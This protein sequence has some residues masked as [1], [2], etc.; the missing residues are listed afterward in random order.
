MTLGSADSA[1]IRSDDWKEKETNGS[2]CYRVMLCLPPAVSCFIS[3]WCTCAYFPSKSHSHLFSSSLVLPVLISSLHFSPLS[4]MLHF[5]TLTFCAYARGLRQK[6][7]P[8]WWMWDDVMG[9]QCSVEKVRIMLCPLLPCRLLSI[10]NNRGEGSA[11]NATI[12]IIITDSL[13]RTVQ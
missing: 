2:D 12:G 8:R 3:P 11:W 7:K 4:S 10:K 5:P 6:T 9:E 13:T 1:A